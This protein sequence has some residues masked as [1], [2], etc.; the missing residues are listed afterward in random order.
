MALL[1]DNRHFIFLCRRSYCEADIDVGRAME[2]AGLGVDNWEPVLLTERAHYLEA[3]EVVRAYLEE[4]RLKNI[5]FMTDGDRYVACWEA[6]KFFNPGPVT[7]RTQEDR[8]EIRI[9]RV[10]PNPDGSWGHTI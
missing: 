2:E 4:R 10:L 5:R 6:W 7:L 3:V 8:R 1:D 9:V